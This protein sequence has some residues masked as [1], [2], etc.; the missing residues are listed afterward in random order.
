MLLGALSVGGRIFV[1]RLAVLIVGVRGPA[2][3]NRLYAPGQ[4][5][6][7]TQQDAASPSRCFAVRARDGL[8]ALRAI[9]A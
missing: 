3:S 8:T 9:E 5:Y 1:G 6:G 4:S 7:R 2:L